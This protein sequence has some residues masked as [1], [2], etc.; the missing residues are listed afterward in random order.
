[1][2]KYGLNAQPDTV[3]LDVELPP[4]TSCDGSNFVRFLKAFL[5]SHKALYTA[6]V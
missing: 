5:V 6:S 2:Y 3:L 1:M 4:I